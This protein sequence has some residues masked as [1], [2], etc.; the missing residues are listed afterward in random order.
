MEGIILY[1]QAES[2]RVLDGRKNFIQSGRVRHS[3]V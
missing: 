1:S 3:F 2:G